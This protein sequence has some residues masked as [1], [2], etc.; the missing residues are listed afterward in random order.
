MSSGPTSSVFVSLPPWFFGSKPKDFA[1]KAGLRLSACGGDVFEIRSEESYTQSR[2]GLVSCLDITG[3]ALRRPRYD[4]LGGF[5]EQ[6]QVRHLPELQTEMAETKTRLDATKEFEPTLYFH[7]LKLSMYASPIQEL[8]ENTRLAVESLRRIAF[9]GG[10]HPFDRCGVQVTTFDDRLRWRLKLPSV[11]LRIEHDPGIQG[12]TAVPPSDPGGAFNASAGLSR[13]SYLF[14]A[15]LAPLLLCM[16]PF[17]WSVD[18]LRTFGHLIWTLGSPISGTRRRPME[19]LQLLP[20]VGSTATVPYPALGDRSSMS[21]VT[22]WTTKLDGLMSVISDPS[23]FGDAARNYIPAKHLQAI[24][25]VEQAFRRTASIMFT[26]RDHTARL[27]LL[28]TVLD[29]L[30]ALTGRNIESMC[31]LDHA[32]Q[33]YKRLAKSMDP[34]SAEVLL[35][36]ARRGIDALQQMQ[37]GFF[38]VR[39]AGRSEIEIRTSN[40]TKTLTEAEAAARYIKVL[41]NATHGHGSNR[42]SSTEEAEALLSNHDGEIPHDL[43]LLA[44]LYLLDL[45]NEPDRLRRIL[46]RHAS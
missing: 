4:V 21:A 41:R 46:N 9:D 16:S 7:H 24:L 35:H 6:I 30:E 20:V 14:D 37:S 5:S 26:H 43:G 10:V 8:P 3:P 31:H 27:P 34:D 2:A 25:T 45:L 44:H 39:Q 1:E 13:G 42:R 33:T 28:F 18:I 12:D 23:I 38:M 40:G 32:E 22:W 19:P 11:C 29:T 15:Y 36:G 17:I